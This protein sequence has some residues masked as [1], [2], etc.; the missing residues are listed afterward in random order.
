M[1]YG[2]RVQNAL[3]DAQTPMN[4]GQNLRIVEAGLNKI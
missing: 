3:S 1:M 4:Q 2:G